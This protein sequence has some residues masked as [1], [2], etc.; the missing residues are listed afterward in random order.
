[1]MKNNI[2]K[3]G[4]IVVFIT[5]FMACQK[6]EIPT[7][8]GTAKIQFLDSLTQSY[9]FIFKKT[10]V[11]RDTFWIPVR[12]IGGTTDYDRPIKLVQVIDSA[13]SRFAAKPG[14]HY[15][16][17]ESP[18]LQK[19]LVLKAGKVDGNIPI[20]LLRDASLKVDSYHLKFAFVETDAL[21]FGEG[22]ALTKNIQFSDRFERFYSWRFDNY[23]A[24]AFNN[25]AIYS[26][27]KH[28]FM[29][30]IIGEPIDENWYQLSSSAGALPHYR[31]IMRQALFNFN[32]NPANIASGAAPMLEAG[33][34]SRAITF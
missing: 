7:Y 17:F 23:T 28:Q 31:N 4:I 24:S 32:T 33:V 10:T 29:Y 34:G 12:V 26:P 11:V 1:M 20:I 9:T 30:E 8:S 13:N 15:V 5:L 16:G 3:I 19:L 21:G 14:I 18:E 25:F 6:A 27:K 2:F 22:K